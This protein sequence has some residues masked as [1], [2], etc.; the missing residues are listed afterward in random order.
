M[1]F[2]EGLCSE[3]KFNHHLGDG[4]EYVERGWGLLGYNMCVIARDTVAVC[5]AT[6]CSVG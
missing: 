4:F 2:H 1:D 6:P 3:Q 5:I